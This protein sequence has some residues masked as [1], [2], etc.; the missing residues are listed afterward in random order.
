VKGASSSEPRLSERAERR[1]ELASRFCAALAHVK[2]RDIDALRAEA[3]APIIALRQRMGQ[4]PPSQVVKDA[5][6]AD[7]LRQDRNRRKAARQAARS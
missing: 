2:M 1:R 7:A 3:E 6:L 4:S 5:A